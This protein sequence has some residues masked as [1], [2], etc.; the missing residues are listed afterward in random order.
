[1]KHK[2]VSVCIC[3]C[4]VL[5]MI[6]PGVSM[7]AAGDYNDYV[8]NG[9]KP[10]NMLKEGENRNLYYNFTKD[11]AYNNTGSFLNFTGASDGQSVDYALNDASMLYPEYLIN[12]TVR[13]KS[14][15]RGFNGEAF[16]SDTDYV[17]EMKL[18]NVGVTENPLFGISFT[19][20][21]SSNQKCTPIATTSVTETDDWQ[22]FKATMHVD[23][24]GNAADFYIGYPAGATTGSKVRL[25]A[26]S[27]YIAK[28]IPFNL[29]VSCG[30]GE[31][32]AKVE[33]GTSAE[34]IVEVLNQIGSV[35]QD[36]FSFNWYAINADRTELVDGFTF[37]P[38]GG[39]AMASVDKTVEPGTYVIIAEETS[40]GIEGFKH[41]ITVEV[42]KP[43]IRDSETGTDPVYDIVSTVKSGSTTLGIF[44]ELELEAGVVNSSGETGSNAQSFKWYV[45]N[46]ERTDVVENGINIAVSGDMKT[47]SI[48]LSPSVSE[49]TYYIIAE[50]TA[51]ESLGFVQGTAI[52]VDKSGTIVE[53]ADSFKSDS[54][55]EIKNNLATYLEI[56]ELTNTFVSK[57]NGEDLANL[58]AASAQDEVLNTTTENLQEFVSRL[59]VVSLYNKS[60]GDVSLSDSDG[61]FLFAD[62]L[63]LSE[64]DT[65]GVT[66]YSLY[67]DI[68]SQSGRR[69]VQS[70]LVG[71][72]YADWTAFNSAVKEAILLHSLAYPEK[73]GTG[74][75]DSVL[76]EK[77]LASVGIEAEKYLELT[78]NDVF[79]ETIARELLTKEELESKLADAYESVEENDGSGSEGG[80]SGSGGGTKRG[81]GNAFAV[82]KPVE[83]IIKEAEETKKSYFADVPEEHWA[84]SDIYFLKEMGVISG[85][86]ENLFEPESKVTREQFVKMVI[87]AF[88]IEKTSA[89]LSF[90]DVE[91]DT[92]YAT[93]IKTAVSQGI[94]NGKSEEQ[95]GIGESITRQDVC[96][97]LARVLKLGSESAAE[98]NFSDA[99][100]V[101]EYA[102][103]AVSTLSGYAVINGFDDLTFRPEEVCTRA[104]AARIISNAISI[105]NCC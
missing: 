70:A 20:T 65:D 19:S 31:E 29:E 15:N 60:A 28:A 42:T 35:Y 77:N 18:M 27:F 99:K 80:T 75:V 16:E 55:E 86:K 76:T 17:V 33:A 12:G 13:N 79:N 47:A 92:W 56:L 32:T 66:I 98:L 85:L 37:V 62:E 21:D 96:A 1:M 63:K 44:D 71:S 14:Y 50:S 4:L 2:M 82:S 43:V 38:A 74:Y 78:D 3:L 36:D 45:L 91:D 69:A 51:A 72:E 83:E 5:T 54:A 30:E 10:A 73:S 87:D 24:G 57:A 6:I 40:L 9:E 25:H 22:E 89:V 95:F 81:G 61:Q 104:Q 41:G 90:T 52:E 49:G 64:I 59:A 84:Y 11:A 102:K 7:A 97:I 34:F 88:K 58:L 93:Y 103:S 68:L 8:P 100:Q 105:I 46:E 23:Y 101:A 26:P 94:V 48:T 39:T 53:I 67:N